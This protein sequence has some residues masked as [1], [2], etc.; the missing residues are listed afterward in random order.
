MGADVEVQPLGHGPTKWKTRRCLRLL[1]VG[2]VVMVEIAHMALVV[3][4]GVVGFQVCSMISRVVDM[5]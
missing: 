4:S 5:I 2:L 3:G 1:V